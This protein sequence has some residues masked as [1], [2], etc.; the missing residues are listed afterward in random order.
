MGSAAGANESPAL[1][2][3]VLIVGASGEIGSAIA[4]C[5]ARRGAALWLWGRD[6]ER[7]KRT[8]EAC[9]AAG[10]RAISIQGI[11]LMDVAHA[12]AAIEA[13]DAA[14][15]FTV[16]V[17]AA[18]SG[19]VREPGRRVETAAQVVR[20]GTVNFVAPAAMAAALGD[21][22]AARQAGSLVLIGSAAAFHAL[23]FAAAYAS[24]KAG[25][26]RFAEALRI[27]LK[28]HGVKVTLVSPGFV[29]TAAARQVPGPKPGMLSP[30][31][32]AA[33][34]VAAGERGV[35]HLIIPRRFAFLRLFDRALPGFLRD[36]LLRAITPP[37]L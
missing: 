20:L 28:P 29:D 24:S 25:L 4:L 34:I 10:A 30:A 23:P 35:P 18:G 17:F 6:T 27:A 33:R 21:R 1:S 8:A 7:L 36:R 13:A 19:D 16:A 15:C 3:S 14:A 5:H 31:V 12:V 9:R 2:G 37:G 26:A 11:D 32:V 22:M